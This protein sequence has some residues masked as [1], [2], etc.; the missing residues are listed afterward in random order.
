MHDPSES[1]LVNQPKTNRGQETLNRICSAAE[2]IFFQK[3]YY[4]TGINDI[5]NLANVSAGT[6]YI[7]FESKQNLY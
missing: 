5:T 7:Y 3:G 2:E 1:P 4:Q 6:F